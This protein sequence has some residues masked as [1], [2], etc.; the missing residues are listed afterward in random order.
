MKLLLKRLHC[1]YVARVDDFDLSLGLQTTEIN[2]LRDALDEYSILV[3]RQQALTDRQQLEIASSLG[4]SLH[5]KTGVATLG[6]NRFGDEALTDISNIDNDGKILS[7]DDRR[8][9][10]GL[11]NRL[12]HTDASFQ[13]PRGR[14]SM[15][16]MKRFPASGCETQFCNLYDAYQQ[17]NT[18]LQQTVNR[19]VAHHSIVHSREC[20]GFMFSDAE[21]NRLKGAQHPL[22]FMNPTTG[23]KALYIAAHISHILGWDIP[24]SRIFLM[25]LIEHSTQSQFVYR[26]EW[27][28]DD[29]VIWDNRATMHRGM[30]FQDETEEREM[31]RVTTLDD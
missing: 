8:R 16:S 28:P 7:K 29:F 13:S 5:R 9:Q 3:F 25:D 24:D 21:K 12:W 11:A 14:Y 17:L 26:H 30:V 31:R 20:L 19:L 6:P 1:T 4:G 15:L 27:R 23:R 10:Y 18:P 22:V 2:A